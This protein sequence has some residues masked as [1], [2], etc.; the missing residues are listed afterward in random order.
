MTHLHPVNRAGVLESR[1]RRLLQNPRKI[2]SKHIRPGTTVLDLGCGTGYFTTEIAGLLGDSGK[3]VAVDVQEGMLNILRQKLNGSQ[4]TQRIQIHK[5]TESRLGLT[6]K[7]DFVLAFYTF[8]E[9]KYVD[10][11]ITELK[12]VLKLGV[13]ILIAEQR[14]H[15]RKDDFN[16][17][18]KKMEGNG[19]IVCEHPRIFFSRAVVMKL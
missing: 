19:F 18:I 4:L 10:S 13:Q 16:E 5:C 14:F 9:M 2:M 11:I 1:L 15:V 7:F 6:E 8:H 3:V 12:S 17:L